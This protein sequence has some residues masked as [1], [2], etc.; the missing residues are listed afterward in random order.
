MYNDLHSRNFASSPTNL[1]VLD[2]TYYPF[3]AQYCELKFA[4][5]TTEVNRVSWKKA[6]NQRK[7]CAWLYTTH[8]EQDRIYVCP[9]M[10][11]R[12]L[13]LSFHIHVSVRCLYLPTIGPPILLQ[14]NWRT[15][16]GNI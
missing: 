7:L 9:D 12:G 4:S 10:N 11:L 15:D 6:Q 13:I 5:W 3:D 1:I 8:C 14:Q 2:V 16:H